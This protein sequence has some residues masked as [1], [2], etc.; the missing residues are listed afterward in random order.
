[1]TTAIKKELK[2]PFP[3]FGGKGRVADMVWERLGDPDNFVE[4][5]AFSAAVTLRRPQPGKIETINDANHFVV[6]FW[7]AVQADPEAV[8]DFADH[9]VTEADLHARHRYLVNGPA[10][11]LF[12]YSIE[13]DPDFYDAKFAGWWVWGQCCWIGAGW[14][15]VTHRSHKSD[16]R[17][18]FGPDGM[19][20]GLNRPA[21][22]SH[23]NR[24]PN[25]HARGVNVEHEP[26]PQIPD[27]AGDAGDAGATG[28]GVVSSAGQNKR[29]RL[30]MHDDPC[31][32]VHQKMP[33]LDS[34]G[35]GGGVTNKLP[36]LNSHDGNGTGVHCKK[37]MTVLGNSSF[38][39]GVHADPY[40]SGRPQLGD[41]YDIGRGV[42]GH[43]ETRLCD[44]RRAWLV[45][46]MRRLQ[47]RLRLVRICYG[48][49]A[50]I[51][52]SNTTMTRL[53]VTGAFLDPPYALNLD[54]LRQWVAFLND[55][56]V[57][58]GGGQASSNRSA[59]LYCNDGSQDVDRLVA[60]VHLWCRKWGA[61]PRVRIA[62]CGY[63]GEHDALEDLG[64]SVVAWKAHG[65][66][67]NRNAEN[68]NKHRERIWFSPACLAGDGGQRSLFSR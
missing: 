32:G 44:E 28:R 45:A 3:A 55:E 63:E 60:G 2:A 13:H 59:G 36:L 46:W 7:R 16:V 30:A 47:D 42:N 67:A 64:W 34:R 21:D 6:N 49:W 58:P 1:M 23:Q 20:N 5:F 33:R 41:A 54:R 35:E 14:C 39:P 27:L 25:G 29:P 52:D 12:R 66:Y 43:G 26:S 8:A 37:P 50:R 61:E 65:G 40:A 18:N 15:D 62:L 57:A 38:L 68:K 51:C 24:V 9:P 48:H 56:G 4:P 17:V 53:G 19:G 11:E 22:R 31:T 10:S